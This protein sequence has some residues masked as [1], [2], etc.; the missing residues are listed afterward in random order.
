[1]I[2]ETV[3]EGV[4]SPDIRRKKAGLFEDDV[5]K[6]AEEMK[7]AA[8]DDDLVSELSSALPGFGSRAPPQV[9]DKELAKELHQT[10]QN[11]AKTIAQINLNLNT[12][13][14]NGPRVEPK[15]DLEIKK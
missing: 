6:M 8:D 14:F 13:V 4:S 9:L 5:L 12:Q 7:I 1:M 10:Q 3:D 2:E 15:E 11:L